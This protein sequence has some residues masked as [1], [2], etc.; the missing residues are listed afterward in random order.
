M[1]DTLSTLKPPLPVRCLLLFE[2]LTLDGDIGAVGVLPL[3][4]VGIWLSRDS[5]VWQYCSD[6]SQKPQ[7]EIP[8]AWMG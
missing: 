2:V 5:C 6:A 8:F 1:M 7:R 4:V 3:R